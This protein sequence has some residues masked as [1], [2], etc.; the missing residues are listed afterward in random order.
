MSIS[1][2]S[3]AKI[4]N[5]DVREAISDEDAAFLRREENLDRWQNELLAI[6]HDVEK[7]LANHRAE[8]A[9][10]RTELTGRRQ[11][12]QYLAEKERWRSATIRFLNGV[13]LK[14]IEVRQLRRTKAAST[15]YGAILEHK[16]SVLA[17]PDNA[18]DH[19][20]RL[21]ELVDA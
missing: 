13:E 5:D 7:Q 1:N 6:K 2:G 18:E 8:R 14:L 9:K 12:L 11:W 10:A 15:L 3:F 19:D 17:D 21:W 16:R 20:A 4:V